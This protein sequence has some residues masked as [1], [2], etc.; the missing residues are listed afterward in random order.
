LIAN[1]AEEFVELYTPCEIPIADFDDL[2]P[3]SLVLFQARPG[4]V[5]APSAEPTSPSSFAPILPTVQWAASRQCTASPVSSGDFFED[6]SG[7]CASVADL[8]LL[9]EQSNAMEAV[10]PPRAC[11]SGWCERSPER[12]GSLA[13]EGRNTCLKPTSGAGCASSPKQSRLSGVQQQMISTQQTFPREAAQKQPLLSAASSFEADSSGPGL[14]ELHVK[15]LSGRKLTVKLPASARVGDAKS[16]I[17]EQ[18]GLP[19]ENIELVC[20]GRVLHSNGHGLRDY[21]VIRGA[22]VFMIPVAL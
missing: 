7:A 22:L 6:E 18:E 17:A 20:R 4:S 11:G 9:A 1:C 8:A 21:G 19:V 2:L 5:R 10:T 13:L 12:L 14:L 15:T 16:S 3:G